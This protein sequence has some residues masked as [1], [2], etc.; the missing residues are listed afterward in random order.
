MKVELEK[1]RLNFSPITGE[2]F[3]GTIEPKNSLLWRNKKE[4]TND[5][6]HVVVNKWKNKKET[7]IHDGYEYEV[8]VKA[9]KIK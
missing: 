3:V 8:S 7:F 1:L 4:I 5:F 9:T 2:V 6:I